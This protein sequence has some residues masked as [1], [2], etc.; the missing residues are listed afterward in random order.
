MTV[1]F[2]IDK[3]L[4]AGVRA[5]Q[6]GD[7]ATAGQLYE[8]VLEACP[9]NADALHLHGLICY[10]RGELEKAE[11]EIRQAISS[12]SAFADFYRSLAKVQGA[13]GKPGDALRAYQTV[14]SMNPGDVSAHYET[15]VLYYHHGRPDDAERCF[16]TC[17]RL[18]PMHT[19]A[20]NTLG[21]VLKSRG[22]L[23]AALRCFKQALSI[24]PLLVQTHCNISV[25]LKEQGLLG[26]AL[27]AL[28]TAVSIDAGYADAHYNMGLVLTQM[29][30]LKEAVAEYEI[31]IGLL[32]GFFTG[33]QQ[34]RNSPAGAGQDP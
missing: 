23:D 7:L 9:E 15:G 16:K 24:D 11:S 10:G 13:M 28:R 21:L 14:T 20:Y 29:G 25:C 12:D 17:V 2:D 32:R 31:T 1:K 33:P 18:D 26:A 4:E 27:E 3:W 6:I 5:Q 19:M 22:K 8:K 34:R 30:R